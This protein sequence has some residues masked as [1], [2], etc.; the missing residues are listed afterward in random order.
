M[1]DENYKLILERIDSL[2]KD[3]EQTNKRIDDVV[4]FNRT[5]LSQKEEINKATEKP[6][7]TKKVED[8]INGR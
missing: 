1:E 4:A 8:Y 2:V 7:V 3:N 5:L 6:Q